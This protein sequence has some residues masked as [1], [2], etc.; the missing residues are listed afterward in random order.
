MLM[1]RCRI[2]TGKGVLVGIDLLA[3]DP[4]RGATLLVGD[5][6]DPDILQRVHTAIEGKADAVLSDYGGSHHRTSADRSL[7]HNG[8]A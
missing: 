6:T 4:V 5:I 7:T 3:V 8:F 1:K 2:D